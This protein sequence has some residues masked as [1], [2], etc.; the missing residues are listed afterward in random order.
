[1]FLNVNTWVME[2]G[3]NSGKLGRQSHNII[4]LLGCPGTGWLSVHLIQVIIIIEEEASGEEMSLF[5]P[6]VRHF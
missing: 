1:M 2:T 5:D 4:L 6:A 3:L